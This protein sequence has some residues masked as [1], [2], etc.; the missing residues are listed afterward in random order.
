MIVLRCRRFDGLDGY[1]WV[2]QMKA[3]LLGRGSAPSCSR[4]ARRLQMVGRRIVGLL[5]AFRG[6]V[7]WLLRGN[8]DMKVTCPPFQVARRGL[9]TDSCDDERLT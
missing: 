4:L 1:L 8:R 9:E 5:K 3:M 6:Y 7:Q 2:S